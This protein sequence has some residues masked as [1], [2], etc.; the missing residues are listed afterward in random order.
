VP[1]NRHVYE[2]LVGMIFFLYTK[3]NFMLSSLKECSYT[4]TGR[5]LNLPFLEWC[6]NLE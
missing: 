2:K 4:N 5:P 3:P 1:V 6:G